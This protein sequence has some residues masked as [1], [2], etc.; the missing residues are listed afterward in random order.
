MCVS[1]S[2]KLWTSLHLVKTNQPV[3]YSARGVC[4]AT[5]NQDSAARSCLQKGK[6]WRMYMSGERSE[7][8][9]FFVFLSIQLLAST[10]EKNAPRKPT[11]S[12][13]VTGL[14]HTL[15]LQHRQA[16]K[17]PGNSTVCTFDFNRTKSTLKTIKDTP[18]P[19]KHKKY[20][21]T[22]QES[23]NTLIVI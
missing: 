19:R 23:G 11:H 17:G 9:K 2:A 13:K 3:I 20:P 22:C 4:E 14:L 1:G 16:F 8:K 5:C 15:Q 7:R 6:G 10:K 18:I 12:P 21:K